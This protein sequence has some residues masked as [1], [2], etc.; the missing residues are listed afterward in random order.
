MAIICQNASV[1]QQTNAVSLFNVVEDVTLSDKPLTPEEARAGGETKDF[2]V[3]TQV[4]NKYVL[5]AQIEREAGINKDSQAQMKLIV[6][7]P[8]GEEMV[9]N[10]FPLA[11]GIGDTRKTR[12]II[13]FDGMLVTKTGR[14]TYSL[15]T[16]AAGEDS[17]QEQFVSWID[18]KILK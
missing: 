3:K 14:Y 17:Y 11:F 7:D 13:N 2:P 10:D 16:K 18:V 6:T 8:D 1:D 5:V 9:N 12:A 15:S 4:N